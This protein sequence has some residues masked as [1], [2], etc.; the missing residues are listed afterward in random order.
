MS[1]ISLEAAVVGKDVLRSRLRM[2]ERETWICDGIIFYPRSVFL[3][4]RAMFGCELMFTN[5]VHCVLSGC[6]GS[7]EIEK[8]SALRRR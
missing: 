8:K 4:S 3:F 5:C 6:R 1:T 2:L 7:S